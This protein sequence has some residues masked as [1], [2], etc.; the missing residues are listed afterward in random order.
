V[1]V[2]PGVSFVVCHQD[3]LTPAKLLSTNA[4]WSSEDYTAV[5]SNVI[6]PGTIKKAILKCIF[7]CV[8]RIDY[9]YKVH[10]KTKNKSIFMEKHGLNVNREYYHQPT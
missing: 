9:F 10:L 2:R 1:A 7:Q 6:F 5:E 4:R 3:K 8:N